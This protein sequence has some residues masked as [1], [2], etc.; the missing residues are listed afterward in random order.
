S[1]V[2]RRIQT[3]QSTKNVTKSEK[4]NDYLSY[5]SPCADIVLLSDDGVRFRVHSAVLAPASNFFRDMFGM[6]RPAADNSDEALPMGES[7][8]IIKTILDIIYPHDVYP[9]LPSATFAFVRRLLSAAERF[10]FMRVTHHV[11]L[12]TKMEPFASRP[13]EVYAL[14]C[15]YGWAEEAH[16]LSLQT[17]NLDLSSRDYVDILK[18]IDSASL[19]NLFQLRWRRKQHILQVAQMLADHDIERIWTCLCRSIDETIHEM[20][21]YLRL[22]IREEMDKFPDG[23]GLR[24]PEFWRQ[25][26]LRG[27]W[28]SKCP[29]CGGLSVDENEVKAAII[30]ELDEVIR[31]DAKW[32]NMK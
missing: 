11:R 4:T 21:D 14:A 5:S 6:P 28:D 23:S 29:A 18:S 30:D 27:L 12:L 13:L 22:I 10:D 15:I 26:G 7:S 31:G 3:Y 1:A 2:F 8:Q 17:L 25:D 32:K 19:Y 9:M 24:C 16:T 20:W